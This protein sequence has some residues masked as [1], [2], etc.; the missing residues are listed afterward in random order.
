MTAVDTSEPNA[1]PPKAQET[2]KQ[3]AVPERTADKRRA[4]ASAKKKQRRRAHRV[5]LRRSHTN[6]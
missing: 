5:A 2:P 1:T 4:A 6:G 3:H